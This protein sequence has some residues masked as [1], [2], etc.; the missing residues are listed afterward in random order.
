MHTHTFL[1]AEQ[2]FKITHISQGLVN[3]DYLQN[4]KSLNTTELFLSFF[5]YLLT[6]L[7]III[8]TKYTNLHC[9]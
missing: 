5:L 7:L 1:Q 4:T 9:Y 6:V 2:M 8:I 3:P